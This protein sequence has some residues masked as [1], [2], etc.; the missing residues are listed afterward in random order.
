MG[1]A[2]GHGALV[3]RVVSAVGALAACVCGDPSGCSRP[4]VCRMTTPQFGRHALRAALLERLPEFVRAY[5]PPDTVVR[6]HGHEIRIGRKGSI[7][8]ARD[9][10]R[11][12]NFERGRGGDVLALAGELTGARDFPST[13]RAVAAFVGGVPM[14]ASRDRT[15]R[16]RPKTSSTNTRAAAQKIWN[17]TRPIGATLAAAYLDARGV[18]HVASAAALRFHAS[19]SHPNGPGGFPALVAGVQDASGRFLGIQ[20]TYLHGPHKAAVE[21]VRASLGSLAGGAVRLCEPH[22]GALL[23]GEGI[24][25]TA[26]AMRVL[27]WKDGACAT[28]GTAGLRAVVLPDEIRGVVIAADRDASGAGQLAAAELARRLEAEGRAVEIF[29]PTVIG[30]DFVDELEA[31]CDA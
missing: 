24:E 11:Y 7:A 9:D 29:M 4:S 21:P 27:N 19:L 6:E 1:V 10:G 3:S 8:I 20:R 5:A 18:G 17:A 13:L 2:P 15:R 16:S 28:L 30:H 31:S 14:P 23:L 26:A 12:F 22:G 25:S